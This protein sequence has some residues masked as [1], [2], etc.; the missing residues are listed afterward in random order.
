MTPAPV[1]RLAAHLWCLVLAALATIR[2]WAAAPVG[3]TIQ[4]PE[5]K[6]TDTALLAEEKPWRYG[7]FGNFEF[8]SQTSDAVTAKLAGNLI[9]FSDLI[10]RIYSGVHNLREPRLRIMLCA[11]RPV[12]ESFVPARVRK[13]FGAAN[14]NRLFFEDQ[15]GP[16]V[17]LYL[18][19]L[20]HAETY[21][22]DLGRAYLAARLRGAFP[23][24]P[25]WYI[26]GISRI[27]AAAQIREMSKHETIA[28]GMLDD[29]KPGDPADGTGALPD[30]EKGLSNETEQVLQ[31]DVLALSLKQA[32]AN[33]SV[34]LPVDPDAQVLS[35]MKYF[36]DA[37]R[38]YPPLP[39][40]FTAAPT[41]SYVYWAQSC[42]LFVHFCLFGEFYAKREDQLFNFIVSAAK[43]PSGDGAAEFQTAFHASYDKVGE[44]LGFYSRSVSYRVKKYSFPKAFEPTVEFREATDGEIADLK[45]GALADAGQSELA[46]AALL[47]AYDRARSAG[48]LDLR[49]IAAVGIWDADHGHREQA[50]PLIDLDVEKKYPAPRLYVDVARRR[51]EHL[52]PGRL[53]TVA[54]TA[55]CLE[56]LG[57]ARALHAADAAVYRTMA[58]IWV[59]SAGLPAADDLKVLTEGLKEYPADVDLAYASA[60][61]FLRAGA[62]DLAKAVIQRETA[63]GD[64]EIRA[65]FATLQ[66]PAK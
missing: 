17:V 35:F 21:A 44:E 15:D 11:E 54:E 31:G 63:T 20:E 53:L 24:L 25:G 34:A 19:P 37:V 38:P 51:L 60:Q 36:S 43:A 49:L 29:R 1:H 61:V 14:V 48:R 57:T 4:L 27:Y 58:T 5:F 52:G 39:A 50:D 6:V 33:G 12:F 46:E 40:M 22:V 7:A 65:R 64:A 9:H 42:G 8:L 18:G 59:K 2:L 56:P 32:M 26:E 45:A 10:D 16:R 55:D 41:L 30:P 28:V 13:E 3:P 23:R 62:E 66:A 47:S